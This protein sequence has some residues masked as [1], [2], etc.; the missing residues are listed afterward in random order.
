MDKMILNR[1]R[2]I[3]TAEAPSVSRNEIALSTSRSSLVLETAEQPPFKNLDE[4]SKSFRKFNATGRSLLIKFNSPGEEQDPTTYLK[5]CITALTNYLVDKVPD[6]DLVGLRIRNTEN[7]QD[8]M[9]GISLRRRD[10]LKPDVLWSV[11]GK[12]IQSNARFA[13][14]NRLEVHADHVRMQ[15]GNGRE[16]T[17]GRSLEVLNAIKKSIVIV[18][19]GF[20]CLAHALII[21]MARVNNDAKYKSYRNG[22]G[23]KKL[24]GEHL[25]ASCVDLSNGGGFEELRQFQ[26]YL[27]DYKIIMFDGFVP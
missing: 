1:A 24:V 18:K 11:L 12:V 14:T 13:L 9:V 21:A 19:A 17:K 7:V 6:R 20:L 15:V 16:K 5:E 27:V 2:A 22:Y 26:E 10:Q 8:K 25:K 23:L 4:T 3:S